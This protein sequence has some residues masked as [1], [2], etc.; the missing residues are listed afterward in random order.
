MLPARTARIAC[1]LELPDGTGSVRLASADPSIQ[2]AID[3]RYLDHENDI[4]RMCE[5]VRL[6]CKIL[7]S[8]GYRDVPVGRT[9]P[10]DGILA[11]GDDLDFWIRQTVSSSRHVSGACKIGPDSDPM[12]AID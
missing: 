3:Y 6:A 12:A 5:G 10:A 8:E 11:S 9:A 2:P 1:A 4:R 7:E